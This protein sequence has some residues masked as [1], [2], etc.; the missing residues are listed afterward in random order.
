LNTEQELSIGQH[1]QLFLKLDK[2]LDIVE[3]FKYKNGHHVRVMGLG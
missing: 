3:F 2:S 1:A